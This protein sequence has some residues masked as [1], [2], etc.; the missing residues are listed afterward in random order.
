MRK[1]SLRKR[2]IDTLVEVAPDVDPRDLDPE[3]SFRDQYEIDS[4]DFL[5]FVLQLEESL[6]VQVPEVDYPKL[7]SLQ[8]CLGYLAARVK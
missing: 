5:N 7:A 2:V 6:G 1:A 3:V 4:V 8:G